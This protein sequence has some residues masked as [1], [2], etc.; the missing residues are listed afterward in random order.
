MIR[1][2]ISFIIIFFLV[3]SITFSQIIS[4]IELNGN[5]AFNEKDYLKWSSISKGTKIY[6]GICDS[7]KQNIL[8]TLFEQ[9]Y[10]NSEV[11]V[12]L[13]SIDSL[14]T[15]LIINV[16]ENEPAYISFIKYNY[17]EIDSLFLSK[18]FS[19]LIGN[20]FSRS[21]IEQTFDNIL[22]YY[23]NNG[24]PF[25]SIKINS[26]YFYR[27]TLLNRNN[28][29]IDI[30]IERE[31]R[32][33]INRIEIDGNSKTKDYVVLRE[34]G[35]NIG[36]IYN[37]KK[38]DQIT[39]RLNKL[40][41]FEQIEKPFF[42]LNN[43]KEGVLKIA[44]KEKVTN[45][46]D[47]L[48]GYVPGQ[49]K[50]KGFF[51]G[52]LNLSFRN[53][54]GTGRAAL[55]RWQKENR[56]TQEFELQYKEPWLFS[57]PINLS[58]NIFQ[59]V[60][61]TTYTQ[62][63]YGINLEYLVSDELSASIIFNN[64]STIPFERFN[65]VFTVY[66]SFSTTIG[67]IFKIDSRDNY[68]SPRRGILLSNSYKYSMKK[69]NGPKDYITQQMKTNHELKR[70]EIDFEFYKEIFLEQI[71]ALKTYVREL[72]GT[73]I[74]ISDMYL[75]GGTKTLRGYREKQ[76][77][78]NRVIWSNIEYRYLLTD[79]SYAFIFLDSGYFTTSGNSN[80]TKSEDF[81]IGYGF[82]MNIETGIGLLGVSFAL[83]KGD[84]FSNG[85]I[86]FGIISEF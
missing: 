34:L 17:D 58:G 61:D 55:I 47:G 52:F 42:Y 39:N 77:S 40:N 23:E 5:K 13:Y 16:N 80:M 33:S 27:D 53:L 64:Q 46:F 75:L 59:R 15:K 41:Y 36:D 22:H 8:K 37:Q 2:G 63:N 74:E 10:Y 28:V 21:L 65:K 82:G 67:I 81:K 78:G 73:E 32:Y 60:Q 24:F 54:F 19:E 49:E 69:I 7:I 26:V 1:P 25:A 12:K 30:I 11:E 85:K 83:G 31:K 72:T 9:G 14:N 35:V 38:I 45:N 43:K 29:K 48:I 44:I 76:F 50:E 6:D 86:H 70:L 84:S 4:S 57:L 56:K 68:Y 62:N 66:N 18:S 71:V 20:I 51:T 3:S 79:K